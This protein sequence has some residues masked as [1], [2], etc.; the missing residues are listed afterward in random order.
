[1]K[2]FKYKILNPGGNKTALVVNK[3]YSNYEKK[4]INNIILKENKDVEQVGFIS[5]KLKNLEMAGGEF[6]VNATRCAIWEYLNHN[7]G[8]LNIKVSG[9]QER[10]KGG[11]DKQGNVYAKIKI[12]KKISDLILVNEKLNYVQLDGILLAVINEDNSKDY[13]EELKTDQEKAKIKLK[14]IM[15]KINSSQ[16][17][18]GI[19][20]TENNGKDIKI[21]PIIWVKTIDT[22]FYETAC[23]SGSL[24]VAIYK[25]YIQNI[26]N[27][28]ILQPSGYSLKVSLNVCLDYIKE[29]II[30]GK[31]IQERGGEKYGRI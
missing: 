12:N 28:K 27:F 26:R 31:I 5:Y 19:I 21:Y 15:R 30:S 4:I 22:L 17:A 24:A 7:F 11:I 13:I 9:C 29:A 10:V 18:V 1:M 23:G 6:C 2:N 8:E 25:N 16:N 3:N 20:L 14:E